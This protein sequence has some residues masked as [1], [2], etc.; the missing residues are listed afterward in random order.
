MGRGEKGLLCAPGFELRLGGRENGRA[1]IVN[2]M[3][4]TK[5]VYEWYNEHG[6]LSKYPD[7]LAGVDIFAF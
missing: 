2:E 7:V 6:W 5:G 1:K 4:I 3:K